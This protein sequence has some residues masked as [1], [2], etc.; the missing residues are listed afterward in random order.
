M[1]RGASAKQIYTGRK[2]TFKSRLL[3]NDFK[4]SKSYKKEI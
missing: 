3:I 2:I 1:I 4:I